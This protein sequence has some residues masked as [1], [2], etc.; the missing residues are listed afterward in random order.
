MNFIPIALKCL[1]V[2]FIP[3]AIHKRPRNIKGG[4]ALHDHHITNSLHVT[5]MSTSNV[6]PAEIVRRPPAGPYINKI[7]LLTNLTYVWPELPVRN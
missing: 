6:V 7:Q 4:R 1:L 5:T 2:K 3:G